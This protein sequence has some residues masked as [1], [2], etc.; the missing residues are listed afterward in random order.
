MSE[1]RFSPL[2]MQTPTSAALPK[3][4]TDLLM[5]PGLVHTPMHGISSKRP[6]L[7][8]LTRHMGGPPD[9]PTC[10]LRATAA[11]SV[12]GHPFC[13]DHDTP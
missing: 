2:L 9:R 7:T 3:P 11:R 5:Q 1:Q 4:F 12:G 10:D 8:P 6:P 13:P